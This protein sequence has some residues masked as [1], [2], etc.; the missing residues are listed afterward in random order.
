MCS[1]PYENGLT[2]QDIPRSLSREVEIACND[3]VHVPHAEM[4][5]HADG[6]LVLTGEIISYPESGNVRSICLG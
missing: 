5:R 2:P 3:A 6:T 4:Y 1:E